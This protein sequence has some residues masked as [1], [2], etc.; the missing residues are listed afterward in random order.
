MWEFSHLDDPPTPRFGIS[1]QFLVLIYEVQGSPPNPKQMFLVCASSVP[2]TVPKVSPYKDPIATLCNKV[3]IK[4]SNY[5][6]QGSYAHTQQYMLTITT[7]RL[8]E[9]VTTQDKNL[10][11]INT[12]FSG[13]KTTRCLIYVL[14]HRAM[15]EVNNSPS[16]ISKYKRKKFF[17]K[18][19]INFFEGKQ[20]SDLSILIFSDL[21]I[22]IFCS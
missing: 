19:C 8:Q 1:S 4:E 6:S 17:L 14:N 21:N 13:E 3:S 2:A 12:G 20:E 11:K 16:I 9:S 7:K 22:L 15:Q 5:K 10:L 18:K